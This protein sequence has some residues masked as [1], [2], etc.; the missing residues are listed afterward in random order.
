APVI[1]QDRLSALRRSGIQIK[2]FVIAHEAPRLLSAPAPKKHDFKTNETRTIVPETSTVIST[3]AR[4][5]LFFF[6]LI[7][8]AILL[9]PALIVVL[10]DGTWL[11]VMTWYE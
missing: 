5:F 6:A 1:A 3:L 9:D 11:E 10:E 8:Q 7:F 4:G 2:G